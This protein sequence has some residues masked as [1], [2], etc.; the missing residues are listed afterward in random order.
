MPTQQRLVRLQ[1]TRLKNL[2]NV[3]LDFDEEKRLTAILGP[4]GFGKSTVLHA[5]AASFQPAKVSK[6]NVVTLNGEDHRYVDFFP[7]TPHGTW[8]NTKF[9]IVHFY[10]EI[11]DTQTVTVSISKGIRQWTPLA[12]KLP[13]RETYFIGV[14][15][16]TPAIEKDRPRIKVNYTTEE[17][18]D[19]DS[20]EIRKKVGYILSRDYTRFHTNR[21]NAR[22]SLIGVEF[23]GVNYSALSMGAGEQRLFHI[24]RKVKSAGDYALI[25]IDEIDLLMH[26]DALHRMIEVL[27]SYAEEKKLQIV[28]TTHRESVVNFDSIVA[29]RHLYRSPI[30]PNRTFCFNDTKPDALY[31]LTGIEHRP[32]QVSCEDDVASAIIEKVSQQAGVGKFVEISRYGSSGN[33]FTLAAAL[34]LS[35]KEIDKSLFVLDGDNEESGGEGRRNG[36]NRALTGTEVDKEEKC[37]NALSRI[38]QFAPNGRYCPEHTL[39]SMLMSVAIGDDESA[40]E[41]ILVANEVATEP[42]AKVRLRKLLDRLGGAPERALARVVD[43]AAKSDQWTEYT[44]QIRDWFLERRPHLVEENN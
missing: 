22:S 32:L 33:C 30:A 42:A 20:L 23:Q 16:A 36:I 43:L 29:I 14:A 27:H 6:K 24:L 11:A 41:V 2:Q 4:N 3:T 19:A 25:L 10:R 12:K 34:L 8:S 26:T 37:K 21:V 7:S 35:G 39:H 15:T 44:V 13:E 38:V 31:R 9:S 5:L 18:S 40:N 17:L 28:F 1:V